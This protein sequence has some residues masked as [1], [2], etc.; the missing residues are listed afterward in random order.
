MREAEIEAPTEVV[1]GN[2]KARE[3]RI[4]LRSEGIRRT[5]APDRHGS[6]RGQLPA[7]VVREGA[8]RALPVDPLSPADDRPREWA[9]A[10]ELWRACGRRGCAARPSRSPAGP[11]RWS[12]D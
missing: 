12:L 5:G 1:N 4:E 9:R 7:V 3:G 11:P 10:G 8:V 2:G 6:D